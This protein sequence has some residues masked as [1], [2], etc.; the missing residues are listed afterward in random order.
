MQINEQYGGR[1]KGQNKSRQAIKGK[2]KKEGKPSMFKAVPCK[3]STMQK[4]A[5]FLQNWA[6]MKTME[7]P[8]G[9]AR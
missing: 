2:K 1:K 7:S 4:D 9:R 6:G 3:T 8:V 5:E